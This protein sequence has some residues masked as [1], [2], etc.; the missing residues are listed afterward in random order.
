MLTRP[1]AL[2]RLEGL[3]LL[4]AAVV[5]YALQGESWWLFAL[6][7]FAPDLGMLG[8]LGGK[9]VG[10]ATYNIA[11]LTAVP[12]VIALVGILAESRLPVSVAL[13]WLAHIGL[14]RAVGYCLKLPTDFQDTHLGK[15]G[16]RRGGGGA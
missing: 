3:A 16:N 7:L 15:I 4:V 5:M 9:R 2:L 1:L 14:D 6:L 11:H 12:L 8:Y 13:I 10:A